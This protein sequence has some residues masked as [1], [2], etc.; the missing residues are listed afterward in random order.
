MNKKLFAYVLILLVFI[1]PF[2]YAVLTPTPNNMVNMV[3]FLATIIGFIVFML[4][5]FSE[6]KEK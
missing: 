2:R 5:T 3:C 6:G 4:M 1:F